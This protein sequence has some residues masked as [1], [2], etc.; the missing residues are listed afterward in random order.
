MR[1][2]VEK[3]YLYLANAPLYKIVKDKKNYYAYNDAQ[4]EKI[5]L[6]IGDGV[7][8]QRYK[9]LG[10]MNPEQLWETTLDKTRRKLDQITIKDATEADEM[11]SV[12]MGEEVAPRRDFIM[13]HAKD[14]KNLDI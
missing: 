6:E 4:K 12:L 10:E 5:V 14:V 9:G 3:G 2:L 11:F 8:I 1:P 13:E 7:A